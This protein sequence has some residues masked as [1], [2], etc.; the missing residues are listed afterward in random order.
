MESKEKFFKS[1]IADYKEKIYRLSW[2][3]VKDQTDREDLFQN[4]LIKIWQNL[5]SFKNQSSFGTWLYRISLNTILDY[6]RK[7]NRKRQISNHNKI[8]DL[9]IKDE[10][11]DIE[12]N[13]IQLERLSILN[14][15]IQELSM[16][17]KSL[18]TLY[19]EEL[20]YSEIADIMGI[21]EKSVGVKLTR[22][23]QKMNKMLR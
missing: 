9:Q 17:E 18:I 7:N 13:M 6:T 12:G 16:I 11:V 1:I 5:D 23:K 19:L 20:K 10:S 3:F 15:C 22:I 14:K 4:I 21:S 2:T 8:E